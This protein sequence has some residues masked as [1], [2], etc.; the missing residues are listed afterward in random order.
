MSDYFTDVALY[1]W[2]L[3]ELLHMATEYN[4]AP[5]F[6]FALNSASRIFKSD[7]LVRTSLLDLL[8]R[9]AD[10]P[11]ISPWLYPFILAQS[12]LRADG[13]TIN[14]ANIKASI[15]GGI[16]PPRPFWDDEIWSGERQYYSAISQWLASDLVFTRKGNTVRF[17]SPINQ[18]H[19]A[20]H[21][22]LYT[23]IERLISD[24]I[25]EWNQVLLYKSLPRN[26]PRIKPRGRRCSACIKYSHRACSCT[27][28]LNVFKDWLKGIPGP[29]TAR[30]PEN[31]SWCPLSAIEGK[32][33]SSKKIYE[34]ISLSRAFED[35]GLQVYVELAN[36]VI[37]PDGS[38]P[39][40]SSQ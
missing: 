6:V 28:E 30:A 16:T 40:E 2:C 3:F 25:P 35:R 22:S 32:Y 11:T 18:L 21:K 5:Q 34:S 9:S 24:C 39:A 23:A 37:S 36:I 7:R 29:G 27:I 31:G 12:P 33:S 14:L 1:E 38:I 20:R 4:K 8:K 13:T 17:S 26:E 15:G 19:P 10:A